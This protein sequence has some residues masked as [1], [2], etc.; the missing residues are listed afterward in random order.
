[1]PKPW[2]V[3]AR[4]PANNEHRHKE[5]LFLAKQST[6]AE[7]V[8]KNI[9]GKSKSRIKRVNEPSEDYLSQRELF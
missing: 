4:L 3:C 5:E 1:M 8:E 2:L 9:D 6:K 7:K